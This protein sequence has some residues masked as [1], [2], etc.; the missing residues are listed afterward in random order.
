MR[1]IGGA[2]KTVGIYTRGVYN[3]MGKASAEGVSFFITPVIQ[4]IYSGY[5]DI[6]EELYNKTFDTFEEAKA[7]LDSYLANQRAAWEAVDR[8]VAVLKEL[9]AKHNPTPEPEIIYQPAEIEP[10]GSWFHHFWR[11]I[12]G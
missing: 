11:A 1:D 10:A 3:V 6:S 7:Y 9:A 2:Y 5:Y 4:T 12:F 8:G